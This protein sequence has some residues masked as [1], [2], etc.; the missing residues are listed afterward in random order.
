MIAHE[1]K[2]PWP[3]QD[4]VAHTKRSLSYMEEKTFEKRGK[5]SHHNFL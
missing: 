4:V 2:I 1:E 5:T 3:K